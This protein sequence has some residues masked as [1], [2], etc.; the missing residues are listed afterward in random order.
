MNDFEIWKEITDFPIYEVSNTGKLRMKDHYVKM[1][2]GYKR[3]VKNHIIKTQ[4]NNAGYEIAHLHYNGKKRNTTIHRLVAETFIVNPNNYPEVNHKDENKLNN[5]VD[6]LEWCTHEYNVN[7]GTRNENIS[8]RKK[9]SFQDIVEVETTI[10]KKKVFVNDIM[11]NTLIEAAEHFNVS[12]AHLSI[13][14]TKGPTKKYNVE[15]KM[16]QETKTYRCTLNSAIKNNL[17]II[18]KIENNNN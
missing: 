4:L 18:K 16:V 15:Y 3:L 6:N 5:S 2:R 7:Y 8:K 14:R 10:M 17:K 13:I 12:P 11:F 9:N 1:F